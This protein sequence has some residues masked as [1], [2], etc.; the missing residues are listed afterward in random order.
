MQEKIPELEKK[1]EFFQA[2]ADNTYDWEIFRDANNKLIYCSPAIEN[3]LGYTADEYLQ[4]LPQEQIFHA[5]DLPKAIHDFNRA[6]KGETVPSC[7]VR[8]ITKEKRII[9]V[10]I[11]S[12]PVY[13][14][15]GEFIGFRSSVRNISHLKKIEQ[16][17]NES[18]EMLKLAF[19]YSNDWELYR[20]KNMKPV[21]CS[22]SIEK[23]VGYT[24][25]EYLS[26]KVKPKD[27]I[28][29]EDWPKFQTIYD[30]ILNGE[31]VN[32]LI[33]R[34]LHKNGHLVWV[35]LSA[36]AVYSSD[37]EMIGMRF[38][39]K[40]VTDLMDLQQ[41]LEKSEQQYRNLIDSSTSIV[42]EWDTK[43]HILFMNKYGLDFLG[44]TM[45]ELLGKNVLGTIVEPLT[46]TGENLAEKIKEIQKQP[47][48]FYSSEN[49]NI[50]KNGER[51]WIAWTNKGIYNDEGKL[52]K[53][54]SVG[55]DRTK[56]HELENALQKYLQELKTANSTKDKF[57]SILAHDLKNP[58]S[59][60]LLSAELLEKMLET[61]NIVK[62][63]E[64]VD[65]IYHSTVKC[66]DLLENLLEWSRMEQGLLHFNP[67]KIHLLATIFEC[68][69]LLNLSAENKK[70]QLTMDVDDR[71]YLL[72]DKNMAT[73]VIR[74][75]ISNA[76]KFTDP[77]GRIQ[78]RSSMNG[79]LVE[80]AI[81]DNGVGIEKSKIEKLFRIGENIKSVG[82]SGESGTGLGL[83]L[84]KGF[85]EK[86]GGRIWAESEV[87]RGSEFKFTMPVYEE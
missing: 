54:L 62:A 43:G 4:G 49:E 55:I 56:Q 19:H 76:I 13:S 74:N 85:V 38:T 21:Y 26:E 48:A 61:N 65:R 5:E 37:H 29:P 80:I 53:T 3:L 84:C 51:V 10:E 73:T 79:K 71:L 22:Q 87:G 42:L 41:K 6:L 46:A 68:V 2:I 20:D 66:H 16:E 52:M 15:S 31:T 40:N 39:A 30:R 32:S 35:D 63:R 24:P 75:L 60:L 44:F 7:I 1:I 64:K 18:K 67:E 72:A 33:L 58:F 82:T 81:S 23:I 50:K 83:I 11:A 28:H 57:F 36:R 45:D 47:E 25:E 78:V 12:K 8:M 70:I 14:K 34:Y 69:S 27:V 59:S 86:H 77:N 9:W 17:L